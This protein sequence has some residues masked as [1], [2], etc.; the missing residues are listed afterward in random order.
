MPCRN[1]DL[2]PADTN[3]MEGSHA[4]DNHKQGTNHSLIEAILVYTVLNYYYFCLQLIPDTCSAQKSDAET[5][6]QIAVSA[7]SGILPNHNNTQQDHYSHQIGRKA[8]AFRQQSAHCEAVTEYS[9][10][11][12]EICTITE[13]SKAIN[14]RKKQ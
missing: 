10:V 13:E 11:Q 4:D 7:S 9:A 6:K 14:A 8:S 5:A 12:D 3:T 2:M 1:W